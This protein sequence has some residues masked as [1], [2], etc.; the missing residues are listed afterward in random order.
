MVVFGTRAAQST[1][2][3]SQLRPRL[4]KPFHLSPSAVQPAEPSSEKLGQVRLLVANNNPPQDPFVTWQLQY[5]NCTNLTDCPGAAGDADPLG[6]GMSNTNQ[7]LAGL[8]PTNP[9]SLFRIVSIVSQGDDSALTWTT[10]GGRTNIVQVTSGDATGGY[11]TNNFADV[12]ASLTILPGS[13]DISTNYI[14]PGGA[15]NFPS[16]YY[17]VRLVP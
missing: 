2:P 16:R 7:F 11:N 8:N 1:E 13:G 5:F 17:R 4:V 3:K 10:A 9:A 15:T 12:P 6:K 14:D